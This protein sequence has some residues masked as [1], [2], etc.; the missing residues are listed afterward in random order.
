ML[1]GVATSFTYRAHE[2]KNPLFGGI[3]VFPKEKIAE[4]I[5]IANH[6]F[7]VSDGRGIVLVAFAAPPPTHQPA[8]LTLLVFNGPEEEAKRFYEPLFSLKPLGNTT[9]VMPY[10]SANTLLNDSMAHGFRRSMKASAA[11][12]PI[13][14][15]FASNLFKDLED[16][17]EKVHDAV[18]SMIVF[19][20][21]PYKKIIAVSQTATAF[22]NRG[23]YINLLFLPGW[24]GAKNDDECREWA[25][26]LR[27][28][29][30][31]EYNRRKVEVTDE[32][33]RESI[34]QYVNHNGKSLRTQLIFWKAANETKSL[35]L[36][37]NPY[38]E[39]MLQ[40]WP[41]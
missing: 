17:L 24:T 38:M 1:T 31:A 16:L 39:S 6:L 20:Y 34:G 25:R 15:T 9:R 8:I 19:E 23:A 4:V 12:L 27:G 22:T 13:D 21:F 11:V 2:Q 10:A 14:P 29:A 28:K 33:T 41:S 7:E 26:A 35:R 3:L 40:D 32:V 36:V 30:E 5:G 18:L 37:R